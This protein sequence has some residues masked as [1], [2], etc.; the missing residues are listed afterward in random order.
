[1]WKTFEQMFPELKEDTMNF[2]FLMSRQNRSLKMAHIAVNQ[3]QKESRI[4]MHT[5]KCCLIYLS[6]Y[7][8]K[9]CNANVH[10]HTIELSNFS[11]DLSN[12]SFPFLVQMQLLYSIKDIMLLTA[13][14]L[15]DTAQSRMFILIRLSVSYRQVASLCIL[16]Y[17]QCI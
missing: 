6:I 9:K 8:E 16:L 13:W 5:W 10:F 4:I 11:K 17:R 14:G 2:S 3:D 7:L 1:M 12:F 15:S